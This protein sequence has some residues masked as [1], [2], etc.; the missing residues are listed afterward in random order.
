LQP[1]TEKKVEALKCGRVNKVPITK[2]LNSQ[3]GQKVRERKKSNK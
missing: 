3:N 1:L 2:Q